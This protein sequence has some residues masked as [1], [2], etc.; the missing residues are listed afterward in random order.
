MRLEGFS[1]KLDR[2]LY[3]PSSEWDQDR[4]RD[5]LVATSAPPAGDALEYPIQVLADAEKRRAPGGAHEPG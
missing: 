4:R 1:A 5:L 2:D 3:K